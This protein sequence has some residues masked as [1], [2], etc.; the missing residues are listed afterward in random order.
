MDYRKGY[1]AIAVSLTALDVIVAFY[2][3]RPMWQAWSRDILGL[4]LLVMLGA[5][6]ITSL[7][8]VWAQAL[9]GISATTGPRGSMESP[10]VIPFRGESRG[11]S[12]V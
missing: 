8:N 4:G 1:L 10:S 6:W 5:L 12:H 3:G 11:E 7:T 2:F 9:C